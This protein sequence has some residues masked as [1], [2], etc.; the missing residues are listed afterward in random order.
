MPEE[1][2]LKQGGRNRRA[3]NRYKGIAPSGAGIVNCLRDYFFAG[4]RFP[5]Y[6][7]GAVNRRHHAYF[8]KDSPEFWTRT[9]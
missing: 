8:V 4:A 5:A 9:Y 2:A 1:L 6:E 7:N 3:I